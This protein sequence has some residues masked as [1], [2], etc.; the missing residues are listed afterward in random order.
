MIQKHITLSI[1]PVVWGEV[2]VGAVLVVIDVLQT[3]TLKKKKRK[4]AKKRMLA[5]GSTKK[6]QKKRK[7]RRE[8]KMQGR[9]KVQETKQ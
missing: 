5:S 7:K 8:G 3:K 2:G 6:H 4:N 1:A 9:K